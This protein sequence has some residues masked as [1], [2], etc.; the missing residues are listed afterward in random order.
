M[1][2]SQASMSAF[3]CSVKFAA[4]SGPPH[5]TIARVA[6]TTMMVAPNAVQ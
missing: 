1:A 3:C 6:V 4:A 2:A 5:C